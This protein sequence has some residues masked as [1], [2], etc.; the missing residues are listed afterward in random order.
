M[1]LQADAAPILSPWLSPG[2]L[3]PTAIAVVG[4]IAWLIRLESKVNGMDKSMTRIDLSLEEGWKDF[5]G[6]RRNE[7][8]HFSQRLANE[9]E[10][11]QKDRM[12]RMQTDIQ[13]IKTL[14]R[15]IAA[16]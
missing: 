16:K 13:E 9:V 3:V 6:H 11:R 8:I 7:G 1:F 12:D 4:F 2:F 5:D 15:E 14:V 10:M